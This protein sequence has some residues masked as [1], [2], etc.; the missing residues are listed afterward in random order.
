MSVYVDNFAVLGL[1]EAFVRD[2]GLRVLGVT[3]DAGLDTHEYDESH[4]NFSLLGLDF[5]SHGRMLPKVSRLWRLWK[6]LR[7]VLRRGRV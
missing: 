5:D 7:F 3:D 1:D 6:C 4:G 2:V